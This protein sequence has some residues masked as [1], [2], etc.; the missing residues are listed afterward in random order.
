[1]MRRK[2]LN[3]GGVKKLERW[4]VGNEE[5]SWNGESEPGSI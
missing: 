4:G 1:M 2:A 3:E 5:A